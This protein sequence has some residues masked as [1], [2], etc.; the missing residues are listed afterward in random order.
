[1]FLWEN[2]VGQQIFK[3][4]VVYHLH[5]HLTHWLPQMSPQM[6]LANIKQD[7]DAFN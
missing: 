1:M 6:S 3:Q 4:D 5:T 2:I 7:F